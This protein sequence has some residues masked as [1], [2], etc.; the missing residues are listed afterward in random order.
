MKRLAQLTPLIL[1]MTSCMQETTLEE[2]Q[3]AIQY[4]VVTE[5]TTR[6]LHAYGSNNYPASF[7]IWAVN[8]EG[9]LYFGPDQMKQSGNI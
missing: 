3:H 9:K 8:E 4:N 5:N 7:L 1:L 2:R 6:A